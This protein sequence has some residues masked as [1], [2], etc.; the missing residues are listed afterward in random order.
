[1]VTRV[2]DTGIIT[3]PRPISYIGT[4][5]DSFFRTW[6]EDRTPHVFRDGSPEKYFNQTKVIE[7][8]N[9]ET[10]GCVM[11]WFNAATWMVDNTSKPFVMMLEDDILWDEH[12]RVLIENLLRVI[13]GELA[14]PCPKN[15][16]FISP[17]CSRLNAPANRG[18]QPA[19]VEPKHGWMGALCLIFPRSV[20]RTL[21]KDKEYFIKQATHNT[22]YN[23]RRPMHLDFAI[24][25]TLQKNGYMLLTH[26]P[27]LILHMGD[28]STH[29]SNNNP[30][31]SRSSAREPAL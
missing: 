29:E 23:A 4:S 17:Y 13:S 14:A 1:M 10:L 6:G 15:I 26:N 22:R 9:P 5:L 31:N 12:A 11:N 16:G 20:L 18:W 24:G 3:A 2:L 8:Q 30:F 28:V 19:K 25:R 21:I 7:H 27:T